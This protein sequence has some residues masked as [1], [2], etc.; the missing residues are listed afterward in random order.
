MYAVARTGI[1]GGATAI[2][3]ARDHLA[4]V[5]A[6]SELPV[7][8]GF[9]IRDAHQVADLRDV[10]DAAVVGTALVDAIERGADAGAFLR[11][12]RP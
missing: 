12:L 5:R 1:T 11:G 8:A 4:R 9:G 10:V 7:A 6:A 3:E 2:A